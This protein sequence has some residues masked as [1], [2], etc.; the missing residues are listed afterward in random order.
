MARARKTLEELLLRHRAIDEDQ[1][2]RAREEQ[3]KLGGDLGR[4]LLDLGYITEELLV[5]AQSHQLGIPAVKP[6]Q[7]TIPPDLLRAF[8][9]HLCQKFGV[10]PVG[11]NL[12]NK[13][14]RVAT[15]NPDNVEQ[16]ADLQRAHFRARHCQHAGARVV[17]LARA[18]R[19]VS[20]EPSGGGAAHLPALLRGAGRARASAQLS[21]ETNGISRGGAASSIPRR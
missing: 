16:F 18:V 21:S 1:L 6:D 15:A 2:R 17:H 4:V 9:V 10:V 12:L 19:D 11:G 14:V 20:R 5:R 3:T 8:P 13:M 7:E